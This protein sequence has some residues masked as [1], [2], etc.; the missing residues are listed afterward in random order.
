MDVKLRY[1]K[2]T[3]SR[4]KQTA[5]VRRIHGLSL[6]FTPNANDNILLQRS[7]SWCPLYLYS[8][9]QHR[10]KRVLSGA[11]LTLNV[12]GLAI[13]TPVRDSSRSIP[14]RVFL[15]TFEPNRRYQILW[16]NNTDLDVVVSSRTGYTWSSLYRR[17]YPPDDTHT[18]SLW[19]NVKLMD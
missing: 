4:M 19:P 8:A 7:S 3:T 18:C 15:N 13:Q 5:P 2:R 12:Y 17:Y 16:A 14:L 9:L 6:L 11:F 10:W 1:Y